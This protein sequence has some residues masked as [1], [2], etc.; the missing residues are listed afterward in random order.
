MADAVFD[1][2]VSDVATAQRP[3]YFHTDDASLRSMFTYLKNNGL[4]GEQPTIFPTR[5]AEGQAERNIW[6]ELL[7][8]PEFNGCGH[9]RLQMNPDFARF[10]SVNRLG[11]AVSDCNAIPESDC[12]DSV[13]LAK[14]I[15]TKFFQ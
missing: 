7:T 1:A 4:A 9:I 5:G 2:F 15:I 10:Y 11:A 8:R 6:L 13:A 3:L 14:G 12:I